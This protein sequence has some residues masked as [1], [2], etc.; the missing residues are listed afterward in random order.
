MLKISW[1]TKT[2][3]LNSG[4][5]A[6]ERFALMCGCFLSDREAWPLVVAGGDAAEIRAASP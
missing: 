1:H 5:S 2:P 3:P 6:E 4:L